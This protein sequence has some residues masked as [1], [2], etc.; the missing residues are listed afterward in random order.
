MLSGACTNGLWV[1]QFCCSQLIQVSS[2]LFRRLTHLFQVWGW[3][4]VGTY[5]DYTVDYW[6]RFSSGYY[7]SIFAVNITMTILTGEHCFP[8]LCYTSSPFLS[9]IY[10]NSSRENM[11]GGETCPSSYRRP[12]F[13]GL[14]CC[15]PNSVSP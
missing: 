15:D 8:D 12:C 1:F 6:M 3:I 2:V 7:W 14:Q 10:E 4:G 13:M 5:S 11:V 9:C